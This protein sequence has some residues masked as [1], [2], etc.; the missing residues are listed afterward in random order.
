MLASKD[1]G[2]WMMNRYEEGA[3][4]ETNQRIPNTCRI[5]GVRST[6]QSVYH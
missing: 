6:E 2:L 5:A 3:I 1:A 4:C